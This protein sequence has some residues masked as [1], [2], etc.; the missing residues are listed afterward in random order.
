MGL[1]AGQSSVASFRAQKGLSALHLPLRFSTHRRILPMKPQGSTP[2]P[3]SIEK[4]NPRPASPQPRLRH[5]S[6]ADPAS[7]S[8]VEVH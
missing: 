1:M 7:V 2:G 5:V 4:S 8:R 6:G 3:K